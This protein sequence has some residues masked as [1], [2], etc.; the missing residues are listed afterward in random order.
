MKTE[1]ALQLLNC[2]L[3]SRTDQVI[4]HPDKTEHVMHTSI[5][6]LK[7]KLDDIVKSPVVSAEVDAKKTK[8]F[9]PCFPSNCVVDSVADSG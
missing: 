8:I 2:Q 5:T 4:F 1:K 6:P 7:R 9:L 3:N